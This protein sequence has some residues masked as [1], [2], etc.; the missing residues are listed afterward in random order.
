MIESIDPKETGKPLVRCAKC[1]REVDH[2][3]TFIEPDNEAVVVC[4]ECLQ[5]EE[6][7]FFAKRDFQRSSRRGIIPR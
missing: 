4:W 2:Y 1:D 5:R 3:N 7:G 6:K